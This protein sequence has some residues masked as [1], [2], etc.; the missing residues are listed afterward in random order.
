[1]SNLALHHFRVEFYS[2]HWVV[3]PSTGGFISIRTARDLARV[4]SGQTP[5]D[6]KPK[7]E[8]QHETVEEYIARGGVIHKVI[9]GQTADKREWSLESLGLLPKTSHLPTPQVGRAFPKLGTDE[10]EQV[11]RKKLDQDLTEEEK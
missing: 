9:S 6:D 11:K 5:I 7:I 10:A 3:F 1:M 2:T 4:L 8:N